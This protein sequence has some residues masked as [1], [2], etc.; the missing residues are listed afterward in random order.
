MPAPWYDNG[1]Q[2]GSGSNSEGAPG[3]V[4]GH[5]LSNAAAGN[6]ASF[7]LTGGMYAVETL[8]TGAGTIALQTLGPDGATWLTAVSIATTSNY[9]TAQLPPGV[10]RW[11][12]SSFTAIYA[13][14]S[15][16]PQA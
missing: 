7:Q 13:A 4:D 8:A 2:A 6:G 10:Y 1:Q 12:T 9:S 15:R 3:A 5:A 11:S 16:I 14:V